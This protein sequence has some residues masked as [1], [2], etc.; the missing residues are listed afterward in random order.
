MQNGESKINLAF[1]VRYS[2]CVINTPAMPLAVRG[3]AH[4]G[5]F[6]YARRSRV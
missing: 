4:F 3:Y 1:I 2:Y 5:G 6:F